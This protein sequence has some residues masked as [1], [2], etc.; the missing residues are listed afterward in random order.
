MKTPRRVSADGLIRT[1]G[2]FGYLVIRQRGSHVRLQYPGPPVHSITVPL[3][4]PLKVGTLH[5]ILSEV[6]ERRGV[7]MDALIQSL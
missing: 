4:D 2:Y 5:G 7:T 3:H 1:L 6:A